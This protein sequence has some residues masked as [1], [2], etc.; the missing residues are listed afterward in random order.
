MKT[1]HIA[2][3]VCL[4]GTAF[5]DPP[6]PPPV[7]ASAEVELGTASSCSDRG[8]GPTFTFIV[9]VTRFLR[10]PAWS[11]G[12]GSPPVSL[13]Q[14]LV[15]AQRWLAKVNP[16]LVPPSPRD[17]HLSYVSSNPEASG[18]GR[19]FW[20]ISFDAPDGG[21]ADGCVPWNA[22]VLMDGSMVE[23]RVESPCTHFRQ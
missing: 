5:G 15:R 9:T 21:S 13:D 11:P 14:A 10:T 8:E 3:A 22:Y 12:K 17:F 16:S 6:G 23:P 4:A 20:C 1:R 2:L 7:A 18:E 19:W